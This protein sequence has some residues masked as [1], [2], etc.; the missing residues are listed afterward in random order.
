M[1]ETLRAGT[2]AYVDTFG[3]LVPVRV[4]R[5]YQ[6]GDTYPA[7]I[8]LM[9]SVRVTATR[10]AYRRGEVMEREARDLVQRRTGSRPSSSPRRLGD[11]LA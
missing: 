3:P 10:G 7:P 5:L 4:L 8:R 9:A 11:R 6:S 2:L 1:S